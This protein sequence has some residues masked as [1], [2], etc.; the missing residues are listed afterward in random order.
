MRLQ[1][2]SN[3]VYGA[4]AFQYFTGW[5]YIQNGNIVQHVFDI[6]KQVNSE[7]KSMEK[8]FLGANIKG[9]WHTGETIPTG[10]KKLSTLPAGV[11]K[12]QTSA[13][14]AIVSSF[15]NNG[16]NYMAVVNK[17]CEGS[18]ALSVGFKVENAVTIAKDGTQTPVQENYQVP[19]GDILIFCW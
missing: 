13:S 12:L 11:V 9:V 18:M 2:F 3:M 5:G 4:V 14:G 16:K 7:L 15:T 6:V 17:D 10:T 19:A 1:Q 8:I